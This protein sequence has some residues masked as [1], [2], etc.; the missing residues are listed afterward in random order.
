MEC[1]PLSRN[2]LESD[3]VV[4]SGNS[5]IQSDRCPICNGGI[6]VEPSLLFGESTCPT[7]GQLLWFLNLNSEVHVFDRSAA[8][9]TRERVLEMLG[10]QLGIPAD[11]ITEDSAFINELTTDSLDVVELI[12]TLESEYRLE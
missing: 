7:C 4:S 8:G 2:G 11:E 9:R 5:K 6:S 1:P 3:M 10:E 12:M